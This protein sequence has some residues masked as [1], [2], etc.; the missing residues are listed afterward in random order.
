MRALRVHGAGD[1]RVEERPVPGPGPGEVLISTTFGGICGS[2]LHYY[3]EG[4]VGEFKVLEPMVLGHEVVGRVEALGEGVGRLKLG[5]PVAVH[6]AT[7]CGSCPQCQGGRENICPN[8]AYLGS[9]ARFPHVQGG[10]AELLAVRADQLRELPPGLDEEDAVLAE[11]LA[12]ALHAVARAGPVAGKRVLVTGAGP[13][14]LLAVAVLQ[15]AGAAEVVVSD[16]LEA[17]LARAAQLGAATTFLVGRSD[18]LEGGA[19]VA[20]EASGSAGGLQACVEGV[21]PG[22][23]IV[24]LG[25]PGGP[26]SLPVAR[27]V[28]RELALVG[29][30]RFGPEFD[31]ALRLLAHGF[32]V[33]GVVSHS[34]ALDNACQAFELA[35]DRAVTSKVVLRFSGT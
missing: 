2:D 7:P 15:H 28:T 22:G 30:Y 35:G 27:L 5:T 31:Q 32:N 29:S 3:R 8:S 4:A 13:I 25:I 10:F 14:G 16:V 1:L 26:A 24:A 6:P 33:E 20:V 34:F 9:A 19:D 12:V 18:G 23:A 11:P 17:P 21:R